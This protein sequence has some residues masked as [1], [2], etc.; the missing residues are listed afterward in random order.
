MSQLK[1][2]RFQVTRFVILFVERAGSTYLITTL[3]SHPDVKALTE[4]FDALRQEGKG[5]KEQLEWA[6]EFLTPPLVGPHK[7]IGFKTK[8]V[9]VLDPTG[10]AQLMQ[11][12]KCKIIRLQRR[13][14]IK[15]V[16]STINARRLWEKSGN[17]NLLKETDRQ[18]A[19]AVDLNEFERLLQQ[20]EQWDRDLEAYAQS[21]HLP[22]LSL[23]YEE[24]LQDEQAFVQ[25]VFSFLE[26]APQPVQGITLK[27][28]KDNLQEAILNFDELRAKYTNTRYAPMFDEVLAPS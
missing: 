7:A 15:A 16:I 12:Q 2:F 14:S 19:F 21:L 20:R 5:A 25:Q 9:D 1:F 22:T 3:N 8:Q 4:K 6:R 13:N 23:Y 27:N 17:W 26:V 18:P 28:T 11:Q 10:F 24:L